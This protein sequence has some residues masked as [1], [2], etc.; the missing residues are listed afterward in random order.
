[1]HPLALEILAS[2]HQADLLAE[3]ANHRLARS[4][5]RAHESGRSPVRLLRVRHGLATTLAAAA[6]VIALALS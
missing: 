3:A 5:H 6:I 4:V 1:M 2:S